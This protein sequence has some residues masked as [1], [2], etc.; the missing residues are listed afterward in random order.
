MLQEGGILLERTPDDVLGGL[1]LMKMAAIAC[2]KTVN[3]TRAARSRSS[4]SSEGRRTPART[5][6][7]RTG[8]GRQQ[9]RPRPSSQFHRPTL[10]QGGEL[11]PA[12]ANVLARAGHPRPPPGVSVGDN[13]LTL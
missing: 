10:R 12:G 8:S 13:R 11:A 7:G 3:G 1:L 4:T 2:D 6:I 9:S 5:S